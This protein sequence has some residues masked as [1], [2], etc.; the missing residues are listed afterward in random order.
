MKGQ[1]YDIINDLDDFLF[2][3]LMINNNGNYKFK[4]KF[5]VFNSRAYYLSSIELCSK[6]IKMVKKN[7][8]EIH[9]RLFN[10]KYPLDLKFKFTSLYDTRFA[11]M[12][13]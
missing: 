12:C 10:L 11:K 8:T 13:H 2:V 1:L 4:L 5:W 7:F 3:W 9:L 6:F